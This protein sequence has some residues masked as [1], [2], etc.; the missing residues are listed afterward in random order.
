M[1]YLYL[2]VFSNCFLLRIFS[3]ILS[4]H[5]L[6]L[7]ACTVEN[8]PLCPRW[9]FS[10]RVYGTSCRVFSSH[11]FA[12][13]LMEGLNQPTPSTPTHTSY[14]MSSTLGLLSI[15]VHPLD[16][17]D[18]LW[19]LSV[20]GHGADGQFVSEDKGRWGCGHHRRR[21]TRGGEPYGPKSAL[22]TWNTSWR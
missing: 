2:T 18:S 14:S 21:K 6:F 13:S 4:S 5:S 15:H 3:F 11:S 7:W 19:A 16:C 9:S 1:M 8:I 17:A 22:P 12:D 20:S 10:S